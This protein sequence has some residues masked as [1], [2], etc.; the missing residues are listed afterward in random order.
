MTSTSE[1]SSEEKVGLLRSLCQGYGMEPE[2]FVEKEEELRALV[3]LDA[4]EIRRVFKRAAK[5]MT[6]GKYKD[7]FLNALWA[8]DYKNLTDRRTEFLSKDGDI[9]Y[10]TLVR[11]EQEGAEVFLKFLEAEVRSS[12]SAYVVEEVED[13]Y[14]VD[15]EAM[16]MR[17]A[18][19]ESVV[20]VLTEQLWKVSTAVEFLADG[21]QG[22]AYHKDFIEDAEKFKY[23]KDAN[24]RTLRDHIRD[25]PAW[26]DLNLR[27]KQEEEGTDTKPST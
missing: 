17:I 4:K 7:A 11:H 20:W 8:R 24:G 25:M 2:T 22:D 27:L 6:G 12:S 3:D 5:A 10:R 21:K 19:L 16:R 23:G 1:L 18:R 26:L 15:L 9:T 13:D 14:N